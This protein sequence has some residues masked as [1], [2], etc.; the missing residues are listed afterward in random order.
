MTAPLF[1]QE[2]ERQ[3]VSALLQIGDKGHLLGESR[4][5]AADFTLSALGQIVDAAHRVTLAEQTT[6]YL[7]MR[8][9]LERVQAP[10]PTLAALQEA[11]L[12]PT[13]WLGSLDLAAGM[14][15]TMA[16]RRR[17]REALQRGIAKLEA[18]SLEDGQEY[19]RIALEQN[20][21]Q[22]VSLLSLRDVAWKSV[23]PKP[24]HATGI[25]QVGH[26]PIDGAYRAI[27]PATMMV[28]GGRT[29]SCK[30]KFMLDAAINMT[31]GGVRAG[32]VSLEDGEDVVGPRALATMVPGLTE[33]RITQEQLDMSSQNEIDRGL[34]ALERIGVCVSFQLNRPLQDVARA[35]RAMVTAGCRMVF[36]DYVQAIRL[37]VSAKRAE[38]VSDAAQELKAVCQAGNASLGL[39]SQLKRADDSKPFAEPHA[40]QLKETGD[41][42][43][44]AEIILLFWKSS[45][46][47]SAR[48]LGKV[49][50]VKWS[51][52]RPRFEMLLNENGSIK[53]IQPY[54]PSERSAAHNDNGGG[55]W[56]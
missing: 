21:E 23:Q 14:L 13:P 50:K 39:G 10:Q 40:G 47:S 15:R 32:Y 7:P 2:L 56:V 24:K 48:I 33:E 26:G 42:E 49:A 27:R 55:K 54:S 35:V 16:A 45:D 5:A 28:V 44:M 36:V 18:G 52:R 22:R 38:L 25:V 34:E 41:L 51:S 46:D 30:S 19:A 17:A 31:R 53:A 29:G 3:Y 4:V 6:E 43:N 12:H 37:G 8:A 1:D 11:D 20:A 9:E